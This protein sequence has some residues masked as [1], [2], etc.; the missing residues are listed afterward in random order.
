MTGGQ[1]AGADLVR[2]TGAVTA[3]DTAAEVNS[4]LA[5]QTG[6]FNGGVFVLA[7]ES[8]GHVALYYDNNAAGGTASGVTLIATFDNLTSTS[9]FKGSDF[10]FI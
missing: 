1:I 4:M 8:T 7:Y 2:W 6:A 3:V 10:L 5:G 9:S